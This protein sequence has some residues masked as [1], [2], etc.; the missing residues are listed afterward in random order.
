MDMIA[1]EELLLEMRQRL[2]HVEAKI[3]ALPHELANRQQWF[4]NELRRRFQYLHDSDLAKRRIMALT[5]LFIP[6]KAHGFDKIRLGNKHDG[7]YICLDDFQSIKAALSLGIS[8][9]ASW[10]LDIANRGIPVHQYDHTVSGPPVNH[11]RFHFHRKRIGAAKDDGETIAAIVQRA[12]SVKPASVIMKIDIEHSEWDVLDE[13]P[14][15]TLSLFSQIV[16]EFHGFD[17][18]LDDKWFNCA[19]RTF[20]KL[21]KQ[22]CLVHVHGNN[23]AAQLV[24]GNVLFP[25]CLEFT[26]ANRS[27]YE[28]DPSGEVFPSEI[29]AP[30]DPAIPDCGLGRFIYA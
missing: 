7:G 16:G 26:F 15:E 10:D 21:K 20:S 25:R 2:V 4:A 24:I 28:L 8:N 14:D 6:C 23:C 11:P 12:D 22:F 3:D 9:D 1:N 30:N 18:V 27:R 17:E 5:Q 19:M 29:D 13:T